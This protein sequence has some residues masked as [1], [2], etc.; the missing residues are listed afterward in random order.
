VAVLQEINA[1][2][3]SIVI[4]LSSEATWGGSNFQLP[5]KGLSPDSPTPPPTTGTKK[6][7][8]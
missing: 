7:M 5:I 6:N 2:Y 4:V 3:Y 1:Y 8:N